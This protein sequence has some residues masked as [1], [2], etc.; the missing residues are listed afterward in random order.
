[1]F[2]LKK[3]I[4]PLLSD[5]RKIAEVLSRGVEEIVHKEELERKLLS[6]KPL[7]VKLGIDP[8]SPHIHLGRA[9]V[10]H[11]LRAFQDLGHT[12][13]FIVGDFTGVIGDTSDKD[14]ERSMLSEETIAENLKTYFLQAGKILDLPKTE[15]CYNSKWLRKLTYREIGLHADAFS[16]SDFI[17][18]D[19][20]KRRL[21]AGKRV[22]LREL[23]YPLMQGYDSVAVR[24]DVEIGG[25]DQRFNLLAGRVLQE[26][27]GQPPQDIIITKFPL[28][29][30][31]GRKMSSSWGNTINIS[32]APED[33]YGKVMR[34]G[35]TLLSEYFLL[36]TTLPQSDIDETLRRLEKGE[37]P[38][39]IKKRLAFEIVKLYHN[40]RAAESAAA[41]FKKLFSEKGVPN[42]LLPRRVSQGSALVEAMIEAGVVSSQSEWRRL[43][44]SGAVER[45]TGEKISDP[46][47]LA[48]E[49]VYKVGK[50]RFLKIAFF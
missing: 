25:V 5:R 10:L 9:V 17:A 49:G 26:K 45:H 27:L 48:E 18:R 37:S 11:K 34:I 3:P 15:T 4:T 7:R 40:A 38:L 6:G 24:A 30:T 14:S 33:M 2:F 50:R 23:L 36:A 42:D 32:D 41:S 29:G 43:V 44:S 47:I 16:V 28:T 22:S 39:E 19:N 35:D 1:M 31:D 21:E 13:V 20:I 46:K 12:P 8:T